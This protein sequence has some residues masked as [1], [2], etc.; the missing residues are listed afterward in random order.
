MGTFTKVASVVGCL[1]ASL[2]VTGLVWESFVNGRAFRCTDE[3]T[4]SLGPWTSIDTHQSAGDCIQ[5]GWTWERLSLVRRVCL[6][7]FIALWFGGSRILFR[8]FRRHENAGMRCREPGPRAPAVTDAR[9]L[10]LEVSARTLKMKC[11]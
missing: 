9:P 7:D 6:L 3:C 1:I 5:P 11:F 10:S 2:I 8:V 4:L